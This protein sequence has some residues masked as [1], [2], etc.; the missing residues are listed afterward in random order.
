MSTV[1]IPEIGH[2]GLWNADATPPE[3]RI[4]A[5]NH[6]MLKVDD[7]FMGKL[8]CR[9][10]KAATP[11]ARC[12]ATVRNAP[13]VLLQ[14][15]PP[16]ASH[17]FKWNWR[18]LHGFVTDRGSPDGHGTRTTNPESA[19]RATWN[20]NRRMEPD[21]VGLREPCPNAPTRRF[22]TKSNILR[23]RQLGRPR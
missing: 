2:E 15:P 21:L 12:V 6:N 18:A 10:N 17:D 22:L 14:H 23:R 19:R 5:A 8:R 4:A 1:T 13:S 7:T 11:G 16:R 20:R 9:R 3:D